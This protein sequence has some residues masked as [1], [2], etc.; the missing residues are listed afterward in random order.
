M[1]KNIETEYK[2]LVSK[3]KFEELLS[4]YPG[5]EFHTQVNTY[6]DNEKREIE[7]RHGAMRIRKTNHYVFT[8]KMHSDDGLLEYECEVKDDSIES[9]HHP[10]IKKLMES[11]EISYPFYESAKLTTKRA[12]FNTGKAELCFDI[13]EYSNQCDYEI[14]YEE[15]CDHDGKAEFLKILSQV[16]LTYESNC[17]SKIKRALDACRLS[18]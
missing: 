2:L 6:F 10:D 14:E 1:I 18:K 7:Q 13:S 16:G 8:L 17:D 3:D 9:L 12:V 5:M 15:T 4:L 11:Y